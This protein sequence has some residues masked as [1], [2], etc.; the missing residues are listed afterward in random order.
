MIPAIAQFR[1]VACDAASCLTKRDFIKGNKH[2]DA[3]GDWTR[4][5]L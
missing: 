5:C 4:E 2:C 1:D 3:Q